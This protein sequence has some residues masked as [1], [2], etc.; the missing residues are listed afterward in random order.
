MTLA[1]S[2]HAPDGVMPFRLH[3]EAGTAS[4]VP[5]IVLEEL[6]ARYELVPV[7]RAD[8][9]NKTPEYLKLNPNGLIPVLEHGALVLYETAAICLHLADTQPQASLMPPLASERRA[10]AYQWLV[11]LTN[12]MQSTLLL[13]FYPERWADSDAAIGAVKAA[14][15]SKVAAMLD[16]IEAQLQRHPG[17]WFLGDEYSVVDAYLLTLCR[18]TRNMGRPARSLPL[19]GPYLRRVLARPAVRRVFAQQGLPEPWV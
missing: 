11:W 7:R 18:W 8:R 15:E 16:Q 2:G 19:L 13:Y 3:H 6:G 17:L 12:T 10:I 4:M 14:A 5:H 9:Q 1:E